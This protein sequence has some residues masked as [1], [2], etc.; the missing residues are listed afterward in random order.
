[1][2]YK[3]SVREST[4]LFEEQYQACCEKLRELR[5]EEDS[6][7]LKG[8]S[9]VAMTTTGAAKYHYLLEVHC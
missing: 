3:R 6:I 7:L 4:R 1:M 5:Q 8:S 2:D 9:I